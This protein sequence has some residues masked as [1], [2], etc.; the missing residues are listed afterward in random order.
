MKNYNYLTDS[1]YQNVTKGDKLFAP[2]A[3]LKR[4]PK[5]PVTYGTTAYY[6][7]EGESRPSSNGLCSN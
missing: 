3:T 5:K 7:D 1:Q 4:I 6:N 2:P